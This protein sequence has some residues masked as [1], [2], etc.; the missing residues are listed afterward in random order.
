MNPTTTE[1]AALLSL[2]ELAARFAA[3]ARALWPDARPEV[4]FEPPRHPEFGDVATNVAF[5]LA[6][7]ARKK[8]QE[9]AGEIIAAA[10]ADEGVRATVAEATPLAG[11]INLRLVPE[12]WQRTVAEVLHEGTGYG[13]GAANGERISLEFGSANPTGP[14]V[15]VQGRTLSIG[16]TLARAMRHAGYDVFVEWI[17]NDAGSQL[18]ALGRSVYARYRQL[19]EPAFPFPDDG[20]PGDY[21]LPVA[22]AL[23]ARDGERWRTVDE[24]EAAGPIAKFARDTIVAEQQAIAARFG[25]RYDLWQSEQELH[26]AG[27]IEAGIARLRDLGAI[28]EKDGALW[29]RSTD[30]G[31]D[32]DR[33]VVRRDGRP[34]YLANDIAYHYEKLQ[35]ADHVVDF[36]GPDHHGYIKRLDALANAYG[37]PGAFEVILV[38]QITL[39]RGDEILSMSKRAGTVVTLEEV[40]D[41]VGVDAARF[42]FV[43]LSTDQPLTFDLELAKK[44][45]NDNPVYYVQYGHARIA[46]VLRNAEHSHPDALAAARDGRGLQALRDPAELALARRLA[47]FPG[48]VS[49]VA[50]ARAPHRLTKYARDVAAE[51]HAFYDA[52]RVLTD[53]AG[54]TTAR[55]ALCIATKTVLAQTLA[56]CGVSAPES[57]RREPARTDG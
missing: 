37:R 46:S 31:D 42:F 28:Y 6:R 38:Q 27:K 32:E 56:L 23:R 52:C 26:D 22:E 53:D 21:L 29:L 35:R 51:F 54:A 45:S 19:W 40:I 24:R 43:M 5:G 48:V 20:Y 2:G 47:D 25:V 30:A 1:E 50:R 11:F 10:L 12:F 33:V 3:A 41:E 4:A 7:A 39:K 14:L 16:D 8:P 34:T 44:Q 55:L 17:I 36:L 18:E 9:I 13:R 57:M 49:G 15:V